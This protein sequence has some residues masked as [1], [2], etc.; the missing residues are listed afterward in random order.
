MNRRA[1]EGYKFVLV[2]TL[3]SGTKLAAGCK[4]GKFALIKIEEDG[5]LRDVIAWDDSDDFNMWSVGFKNKA[6]E[7]W[8]QMM[9]MS[10]IL[11]Q[12]KISQ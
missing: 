8:L 11:G 2:F 12:V 4:E 10:P 1:K 7:A 3:P 9:E 6:P 5:I